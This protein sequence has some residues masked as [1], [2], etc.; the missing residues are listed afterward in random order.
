MRPT[1]ARS[2]HR[3]RRAIPIIRCKPKSRSSP[4]RHPRARYI[5]YSRSGNSLGEPSGGACAAS[6]APQR[7]PRKH[8]RGDDE[9][10]DLDQKNPL[11]AP[12]REID[13]RMAAAMAARSSWVSCITSSP[14]RRRRPTNRRRRKIHGRSR[15]RKIRRRLS[16]TN[17]RTRRT[18]QTPCAGVRRRP[19]AGRW[20]GGYFKTSGPPYCSMKAAFIVFLPLQS[21][22]D[23]L[24]ARRSVRRMVYRACNQAMAAS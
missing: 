16:L 1:R 6:T 11:H 4:D 3:D 19:R 23:A 24:I 9:D 10:R 21:G 8:Q 5:T 14:T 17:P 20:R 2:T 18:A 7:Q 13:Q 12:R 22:A 15:R